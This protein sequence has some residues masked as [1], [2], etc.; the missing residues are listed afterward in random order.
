MGATLI[1][2]H[3]SRRHWDTCDGVATDPLGQAATYV[4]DG[5]DHLTQVTDRK[6]QATQ[7]Q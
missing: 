3:V 5:N 4:Y 7:Y 1:A 2:A 6:G